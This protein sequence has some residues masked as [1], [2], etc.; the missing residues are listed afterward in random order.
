MFDFLNQSALSD[1]LPAG[2]DALQYVRQWA[3]A[4]VRAGRNPEFSDLPPSQAS[5]A[6]QIVDE[7]VM[8]AASPCRIGNG[9]R[10][11]IYWFLL[12]K[13]CSVN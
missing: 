5:L 6:K 2:H 13:C 12:N 9:S 8:H 3:R 11:W 1:V 10:K 4:A 7:I